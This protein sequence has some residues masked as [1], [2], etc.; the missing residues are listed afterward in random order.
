M[1]KEE[2]G[3]S[4]LPRLANDT[5]VRTNLRRTNT[6]KGLSKCPTYTRMFLAYTGERE[7]YSKPHRNLQRNH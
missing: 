2:R 7:S 1:C 4:E 6:D 3:H 5:K